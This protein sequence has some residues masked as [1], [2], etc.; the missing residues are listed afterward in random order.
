MGAARGKSS[1]KRDRTAISKERV[2]EG[3]WISENGFHFLVH[4]WCDCDKKLINAKLRLGWRHSCVVVCWWHAGV[5]KRFPLKK[6]KYRESLFKTIWEMVN[7]VHQASPKSLKV[8]DKIERFKKSSKVSKSKLKN[9][10]QK[11]KVNKPK[12]KSQVKKSS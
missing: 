9:Q 12:S 2:R 10:R 3:E 4:F 11:I 6:N 7:F 1:K 5:T 8:R